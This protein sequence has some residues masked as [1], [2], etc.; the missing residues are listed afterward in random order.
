[1]GEKKQQVLHNR[2]NKPPPV[3][4]RRT[5]HSLRMYCPCLVTVPPVPPIQRYINSLRQAEAEL[6]ALLPAGQR[7]HKGSLGEGTRSDDSEGRGGEGE[8][9]EEE[10]DEGHDGAAAENE[11]EGAWEEGAIKVCCAKSMRTDL[12]ACDSAFGYEELTYG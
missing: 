7:Q 4:G 8:E 12:S 2:C 1:M 10:E 9:E 6:E 3:T 11:A 5:A